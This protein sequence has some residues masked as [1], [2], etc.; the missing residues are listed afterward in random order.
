MKIFDEK[1]LT[2]KA[3]SRSIIT[4]ILGIIICLACLCS[5]TWAWFTDSVEYVGNTVKAGECHLTITL[6]DENGVELT[7]ISQ[8]VDLEK[9]VTYTVT[10]TLP[11]SST[12]GYCVIETASKIY[13][14]D[15]LL[16]HNNTEDTV[17]TFYVV[18]ES[19]MQGV[20]FIKRWG[21]FSNS[22][23]V[24]ANQTLTIPVQAGA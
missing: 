18:A 23:D 16:Y 5:T 6:K 9:D 22:P 1:K 13:F 7:D 21:I 11:N 17:I 19:D 20:K 4:S 24:L 14:S 2:D 3:F 15:Y 10:L 12:S 8:G